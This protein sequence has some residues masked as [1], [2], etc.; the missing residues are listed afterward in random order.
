MTACSSIL[1]LGMM[2]LCLFI[3]TSVWTSSDSIKI[4]FDSIG[5]TLAGLLIPIA[6]GIFVK[7]KWPH[8][9]KKILK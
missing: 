2:P 3:Y 8:I 6:V 9:A 4:P 1:A 7:S 5:I